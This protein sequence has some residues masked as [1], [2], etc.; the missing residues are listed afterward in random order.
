V[1]DARRNDERA[2]GGVADSLHIPLHELADRLHE[3]P[4]GNVWV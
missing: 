4:P 3:V 2:G 1:I